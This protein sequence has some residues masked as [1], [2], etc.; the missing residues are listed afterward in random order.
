MKKK[1]ILI[2][3]AIVPALLIS[4]LL[5]NYSMHAAARQDRTAK[6]TASTTISEK[7]YF[8]IRDTKSKDAALKLDRRLEKFSSSQKEKNK[9][10]RQTMM[11]AKVKK[12]GSV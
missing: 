3:A 1:P 12:A 7:D 4:S 8:D 6:R 11:S 5:W 2:S 10:V 9:G